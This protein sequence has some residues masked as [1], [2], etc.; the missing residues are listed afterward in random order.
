VGAGAAG[1]TAAIRAAEGGTRVTLLNAHP[2]V[3]LKILMSG[4]TRC[5]VT[6]REVGPRDFSGGSQAFIARVLRAFTAEQAREWFESMGVELKL[7]ET[8]K[9]FPSTDDAHTVLDALLDA[10]R[11]AGV[12]LRAGARVVRLERLADGEPAA[13][14]DVSAKRSKREH[15]HAAAAPNAVGTRFR[16][17]IQHVHDSAAF[18]YKGVSKHRGEVWTLPPKA[19]DEW[20]EADAVILSTGG[21]S[22]PRTG[23]DGTGYALATSL[24]HTLEPPV[25]ALTPLTASDTLCAEAQGVTLDA[26]LTLRVDGK[27]MA[28]TRG[29]L[30]FAHFGYTGPVA[31]DLS[32]HWHRAEGE[33]ER[34]VEVSFIPGETRERLLEWWL[35]AVKDEPKRTVRRFL[36]ERLPE[37]LVVLLSREARVEPGERLSQV[38][39]D[40]RTEL[41][42]RVVARALPVTGTLGYEKAEVTA[43]GVSLSEVNP[44]TLESRIAPGLY[45]CGEILDVEGR[46]GGFNFQFAWSSGTVAGRA[47]G[48]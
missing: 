47:A 25:P 21:L 42:E 3:G 2:K 12:T 23:S 14:I 11:V 24:G 35:K 19:P 38:D 9:Y 16:L 13:H 48:H 30:L 20:L 31:L 27:K 32:R 28:T 37:R 6:H 43:G 18:D 10:V 29:S 4:G 44:S 7:E 46:L 8:G 26:E 45:L 17:G 36:A 22:F 39:R 40:R 5:N 15:A 41:I 1:L 33:G 34:R